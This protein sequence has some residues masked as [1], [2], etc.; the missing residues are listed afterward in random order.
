MS[1]TD[2]TM[3]A[4]VWMVE[5]FQRYEFDE[6]VHKSEHTDSTSQGLNSSAEHEKLQTRGKMNIMTTCRRSVDSNPLLP[7]HSFH[8]I[9]PI[10]CC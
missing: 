8:F 7:F 2:N 10:S 1:A 6:N 4:L 9:I 5:A 3:I